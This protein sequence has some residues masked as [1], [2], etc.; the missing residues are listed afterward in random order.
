MD[1][2]LK[3]GWYL[4]SNRDIIAMKNGRLDGDT[5]DQW[6]ATHEFDG[7]TE[8]PSPTHPSPGQ[9]GYAFQ[10]LHDEDAPVKGAF[11]M[12]NPW[13]IKTPPMLF[14]MHLDPFYFKTNTLQ[15]CK[16]ID[17][18]TFNTN[19]DNAQII[20]YPRVNHSFVI[21]KEHLFVKLY[22][23]KEKNAVNLYNI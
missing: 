10:Y 22:L 15:Y 3:S 9:M 23:L 18:D 11:K 20:F 1:D 7:G 6:V 21:P 2:W 4:L 5:G 14:N 13:N 19:Y 12:R 17:T 8:M 16:V